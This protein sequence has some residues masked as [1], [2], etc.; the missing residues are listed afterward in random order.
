[1]PSATAN[2]ATTALTTVPV[3]EMFSYWLQGGRIS[4]GFLGGAQIDR[5]ANLNTTV[6]GPY[7]APKVRLPGGGGAPE[8][9][10]HCKQTF[11]TMALNQRAFVDNLPFITSFRSRPGR[12]S[13]PK[14]ETD[15]GRPDAS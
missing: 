4:I 14:P 1:M 15:H 3:P 5:Y 8:I 9:G 13:P 10:A 2:C 7:D 6:I 12:R 11:I